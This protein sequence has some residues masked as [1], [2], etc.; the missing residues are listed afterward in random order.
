[1]VIRKFDIDMI[2]DIMKNY[3]TQSLEFKELK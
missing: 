1:M 3:N 2:K